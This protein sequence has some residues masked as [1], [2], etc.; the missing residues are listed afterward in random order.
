[1][2]VTVIEFYNKLDKK[3][4]KVFRQNVQNLSDIDYNKFFYRL[5]HNS[6]TTLELAV[7]NRIIAGTGYVVAK[8]A[9]DMYE[10]IKPIQL[11]G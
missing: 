10:K 11:Q 3:Q 1:M 4:Q 5:K 7:I 9:Y 8:E 6:W 2:Q